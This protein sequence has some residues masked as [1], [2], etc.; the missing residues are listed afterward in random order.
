MSRD[1]RMK[2]RLAKE[3]AQHERTQK[4]KAA[5]SDFNNILDASIDDSECESFSS[6][7]A[8][9]YT[10]PSAEAK[11][12]AE[13]AE[14]HAE[15]ERDAEEM[16]KEHVEP[17]VL[18]E[19]TTSTLPTESS[20]DPLQQA[21]QLVVERMIIAVA[22][23][24]ESSAEP[25]EPPMEGVQLVVPLEPS[26][27]A[28]PAE[29]SAAD[30]LEPPIDRV[31]LVVPLEPSAVVVPTESSV[32]PPEP[33][34]PDPRTPEPVAPWLHTHPRVANCTR[35]QLPTYMTPM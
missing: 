10:S 8:E 19:S 1:E 6:F 3:K 31:Q 14:L 16:D 11:M 21:V 28:V 9:T 20:A 5:E 35:A 30:P 29:S 7:E 15:M 24:A 17:V 13:V 26:A 34:N 25:P 22:L 27:V 12:H 33:V 32:D 2:Q 23:P 18:G 4:K